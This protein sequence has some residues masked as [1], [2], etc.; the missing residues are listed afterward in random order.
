MRKYLAFLMALVMLFSIT[1]PVT[2]HDAEGVRDSVPEFAGYGVGSVGSSAL[3]PVDLPDGLYSY[4]VSKMRNCTESIDISSYRIDEDELHAL[5]MD[6]T[7][8]EPELFQ[9]ENDWEYFTDN[10]GGYITTFQPTYSMSLSRYTEALAQVRKE[11]DRVISYV[12]KSWTD[13][14]KALY[15][16]DYLIA[17]YEYDNDLEIRNIY[18]FIRTG[19]GVCEAYQLYYMYLL[20]K[21]N[22]PNDYIVSESMNHVWNRVSIGGS[23]YNVDVT[24]DE[25]NNN[26]MAETNHNYFLVSDAAMTDHYGGVSDK[27]CT[28]KMYDKH[29]WRNATSAIVPLNDKWYTIMDNY[30]C[31][32]VPSSGAATKVF[33]LTDRWPSDNEGHVWTQYLSGLSAYKGC[34]MFIT[35]DSFM[36]Y[37]PVLGYAKTL[38]TLTEDGYLFDGVV[39]PETGKYYVTIGAGRNEDGVTKFY[40]INEEDLP[41]TVTWE[42]Y[43]RDAATCINPGVIYYRAKEN[44]SVTKT[45]TFPATGH[46]PAGSWY[47]LSDEEGN[48]SALYQYCETCGR[49]C[50]LTPVVPTDF[51]GRFDDIKLGDWYTASV[52]FAV[53]RGLFGGMSATRFAPNTDMSRAMLVTVLWRMEGSPAP[54]GV[55]PFTDVKAGQW[56]TDAVLWAYENNIVG[57]V[58]GGRFAPDDTITREQLATI[59]YRY[60][61]GKG[62]TLDLSAGIANFPDTD[63]VSSY[64]IDSFSW[65]RSAGIVDGMGKGDGK[66]YLNPT[67]YATRAQVATMLT[68]FIVFVVN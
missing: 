21:L 13:L 35:H 11:A 40:Q 67:G 44:H 42:E 34:L 50:N 25:P 59:L 52:A 45:E 30:I 26:H 47:Y 6:I 23:W 14:E 17:W 39:D 2:A 27:V 56:Y 46:T 65:A 22:I 57:G 66:I 48:V 18:D 68:R 31:E 54:K 61:Q 19:E 16:H 10:Y 4:V 15:L 33:E 53:D 37:N 62:Y 43:K 51:D 49:K 7:N 1:V 24:W 63:S 12:D 20:N 36:A 28:S 60:A 38:A 5:M 9:L 3:Q 29:S 32:Y 55:N 41:T 64:A 8:S 58:G